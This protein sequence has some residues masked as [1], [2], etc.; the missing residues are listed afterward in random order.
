MDG[1]SRIGQEESKIDRE[2]NKLEQRDNKTDQR[3]ISVSSG[4]FLFWN[5]ISIGQRTVHFVV[6]FICNPPL[7]GCLETVVIME[8]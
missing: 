3:D 4:T 8:D 6:T 2:D 5:S 7:L 1:K